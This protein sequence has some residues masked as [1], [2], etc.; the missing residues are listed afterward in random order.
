MQPNRTREPF[1]AP[2]FVFMVSLFGLMGFH[3]LAPET[4]L[5]E[6]AKDEAEERARRRERGED[7]EFGRNYF[8]ERIRKELR[9]SAKKN[10]E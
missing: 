1:E 9:A 5:T 10:K 4:R 8:A 7:V 3:A 6:W 2:M